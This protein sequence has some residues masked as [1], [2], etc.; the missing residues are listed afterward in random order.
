MPNSAWWWEKAWSEECG[1]HFIV[2][3]SVPKVVSPDGVQ[4]VASVGSLEYAVMI[5]AVPDLYAALL[6]I[7]EVWDQ[8]EL[9]TSAIG[10]RLAD[11][12]IMRDAFIALAKARGE[13]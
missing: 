9:S 5:A 4:W 10:E 8:R 3:T 13:K 11:L 2:A 7:C 1:D 6:R 12:G